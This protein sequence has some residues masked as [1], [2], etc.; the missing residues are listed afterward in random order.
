MDIVIVSVV[1]LDTAP[2]IQVTSDIWLGS[3]SPPHYINITFTVLTLYSC[4]ALTCTHEWIR[5]KDFRTKPLD[6]DDSK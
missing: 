6:I 3:G 4:L 1:Y 5:C 2:F